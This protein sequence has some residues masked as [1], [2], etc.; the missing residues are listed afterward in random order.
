MQLQDYPIPKPNT[1]W[2]LHDSANK[3]ANPPDIKAHAQ[4]LRDAGIT[5][6][7]LLC[8][9]D[10]KVNRAKEYIKVG[11]MPVIR[12]YVQ[13]PHPDYVPNLDILKRYA[14]V[15]VKYVEF[16][17]EPNIDGEW[18][19]SASPEDRPKL[20][21]EQWL[22]GAE[23]IK[24]AG[25]IPCHFAMTPGGN[26]NHRIFTIAMVGHMVAAAG[27]RALDGSI[28]ATH[29]RPLN[30]P[31]DLMPE[32]RSPQE[33]GRPPMDT[34]LWE[35]LW[36]HDHYKR[37]TGYSLPVIATEAG[38]FV[39]SGDDHNYPTIT[40]S[41]YTKYNKVTFQ[42]CNPRARTHFP[43]WF[44]GQMYWLEA[45]GND[46]KQDT[47]FARWLP[48]GPMNPFA[49]WLLK[50]P[51]TWDSQVTG[52]DA[53]VPP[54]EETTAEDIRHAGWQALRIPYN[55]TAAFQSYA[56]KHGLGFP[57]TGEFDVGDIRAQGY[58]NGIVYARIGQWNKVK[59]LRW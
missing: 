8:R 44:I 48:D 26:I 59:T 52:D 43:D 17:N 41:L 4:A 2:G 50:N 12:L 49:K 7:K 45:V 18:S 30:H 25:M 57:V 11:I 33:L 36:Y 51:A 40:K 14:A 56:R 5:W 1:R 32:Y 23:I 55:P 47:L 35:I 20:V 9:N 42:L 46:W 38:Y 21:A 34:G 37:A 22:R 27:K 16:G 54:S 28:I 13:G 29:P 15:G 6:Y 24:K 10:N 53:P 19:R 58:A 3:E 39:G 31:P